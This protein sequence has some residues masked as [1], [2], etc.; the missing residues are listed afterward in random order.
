MRVN[1]NVIENVNTYKQQILFLSHNAYECSMHSYT[2]TGG[3]FDF[4][5]KNS[6]S[7]SMWSRFWVRN[8]NFL[9]Y[10]VFWAM[11]VTDTVMHAYTFQLWKTREQEIQESFVLTKN[12]FGN[13]NWKTVFSLSYMLRR[14]SLFYQKFMS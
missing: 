6:S 8:L 7:T 5:K 3:W 12:L 4:C 11:I 13:F 14:H 9:L 2:Q 10:F 1:L